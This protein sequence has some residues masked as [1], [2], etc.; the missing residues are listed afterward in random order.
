MHFS[1]ST[2]G[3][4]FPTNDLCPTKERRRRC[5]QEAPP[6]SPPRATFF[7]P[8]VAPS[9]RYLF[10]NSEFLGT[11][12]FN[13]IWPLHYFLLSRY[14]DWIFL[15]PRS[16]VPFQS[17]LVVFQSPPPLG[18]GQRQCLLTRSLSPSPLCL[19]SPSPLLSHVSFPSL[20][21]CQTTLQA[22]ESQVPG[23]YCY[24][25]FFCASFK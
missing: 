5:V 12:W 14:G 18:V 1:F 2:L 7:L 20:S 3:E 4:R 19:P 23:S 24:R 22:H 13:Y 9:S 15:P 16:L 25:H 10:S 8:H 17:F 21:S 11:M 6:H